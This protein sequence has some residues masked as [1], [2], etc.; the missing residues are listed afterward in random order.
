MVSTLIW[1]WSK[2]HTGDESGNLLFR[3]TARNFNPMVAMCGKITIAEVE[4]LVPTG[5]L[6]PD[7]IHTQSIFVDHI[8][9]TISQK[10]IEQ[11]TV[12]PS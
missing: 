11:R 7:G 2:A 9:Q 1:L 8:L 6:D 12:Q 10:R 4:H 5:T 3:M